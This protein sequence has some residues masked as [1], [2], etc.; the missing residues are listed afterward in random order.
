MTR[1]APLDYRGQH[2]PDDWPRIQ[3]DV[4][5]DR[6]ATDDEVERCDHCHAAVLEGELQR[7]LGER[8]CDK[9]RPLCCVCHDA[10]VSEPQEFCETCAM[11]AMG[12][13][14]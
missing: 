9:C 12:V 5:D 1:Y 7:Y 4:D 11:W 8:L 2:D 14:V 3:T 10:P 6:P 13:E